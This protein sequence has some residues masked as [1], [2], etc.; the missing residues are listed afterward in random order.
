M[1]QNEFHFGQPLFTPLAHLMRPKTLIQFLGQHHLR[2]KIIAWKN[3]PHSIVLWGPPGTGKTTLAILL[4]QEIKT[5]FYT[6]NAVTDG[7]N[8]LKKI[9]QK[10]K[11]DHQFLG[12]NAVLFIDEIH[13]FNKAQQDALLADIEQGNFIFIGATTEWPQTSMNKAL[14]SRIRYWEL[15]PLDQAEIL[16]LLN[17]ATRE[18]HRADLKPFVHE[19]AQ[20]CNGDARFALNIFSAL[21]STPLDK[22]HPVITTS[23]LQDALM[24]TRLYDKNGTRHYDLISAFIKSIRGSDPDAAL[25]WLAIM[26]DGKEDPIF[27]ARRLMILAS[28][29]IGLAQSQALAIATQAHYVTTHIGMPEARI[30]LSHA[31]IF[32]ALAPKSNSAY[33]AIEQALLQV[34]KMPTTAIPQHL[35]NNQLHSNYQYPHNFEHHYISQQYLPDHLHQQKIKFYHPSLEGAEKSMYEQ[36]LKKM[37]KTTI[38]E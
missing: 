12:T 13:R 37:N 14:L 17:N 9:T 35:A 25:F 26:L 16:T 18:T 4:A 33:K 36:H 15:K 23:D 32:L 27:I 2:P 19:I 3:A 1:Q 22:N 5:Q 29:D 31:T 21:S 11:Q 24:Q 7:V 6:L 10:I 30:T 38:E 20:N 28:E 34:Q 8:D